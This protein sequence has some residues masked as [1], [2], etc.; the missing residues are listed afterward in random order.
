MNDFK[1]HV[2]NYHEKLIKP[3][4][5]STTPPPHYYKQNSQFRKIEEFREFDDPETELKRVNNEIKNSQPLSEEET[6]KRDALLQQGFL[7][8]KKPTTMHLLES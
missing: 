6:A 2:F 3:E 1:Y 5:L 7:T 4:I 8:W